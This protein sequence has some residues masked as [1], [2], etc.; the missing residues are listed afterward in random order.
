M[1]SIRIIGVMGTRTDKDVVPRRTRE[2]PGRDFAVIMY[3]TSWAMVGRREFE[4][5]RPADPPLD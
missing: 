5:E 3:T 4:R 2:T 1:V